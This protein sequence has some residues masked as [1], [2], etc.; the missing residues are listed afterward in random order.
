[1]SRWRRCCFGAIVAFNGALPLSAQRSPI[2]FPPCVR[3][4]FGNWTPPL[5]WKEAGHVASPAAVA[6]RQRF[7]RDSV[8]ALADSAR[9]RG[10]MVWW[11]SPRGPRL[12][13][14]PPF[15]PVGVVIEL[16]GTWAGDS[17]VGEAHALVADVSQRVSST[18]AKVLRNNCGG[19]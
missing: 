13:V 3:V 15:W 10:E 5:Q 8:F 1:M 16:K 11:T 9:Q 2:E 18:T 4:A 17:L 19:A 7:L 12:L 14:F 6:E